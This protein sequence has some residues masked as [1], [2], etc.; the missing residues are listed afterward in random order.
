M[1]VI[2]AMFWKMFIGDQQ[3]SLFS[4]YQSNFMSKLKKKLITAD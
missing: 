2:G 4:H 1:L 3:A